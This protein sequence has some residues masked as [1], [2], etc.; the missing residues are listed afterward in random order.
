M[1]TDTPDAPSASAATTPRPSPIA[2][3]AITGSLTASTTCGT[4]AIVPTSGGF[5]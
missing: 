4:K 1:P 5:I 2:P 3:A